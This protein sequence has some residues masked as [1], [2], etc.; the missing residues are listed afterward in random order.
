MT[1]IMCHS[2]N[3]VYLLY[4][5]KYYSA[6]IFLYKPW[7]PE[8]VFQLEIIIIVLVISSFRFIWISMLWVYGHNKFVNSISAEIDFRRQNLTSID[9]LMLYLSAIF[10]NHLIYAYRPAY[11]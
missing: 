1:I 8:F 6:D 7:R 11:L 9:S 5:E 10:R 2:V 3:V 4:Y